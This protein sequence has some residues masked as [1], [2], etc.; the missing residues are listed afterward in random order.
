MSSICVGQ[1]F[2][3][4]VVVK[5]GGRNKDRHRS[6]LCKCKC[7]KKKKVE[8][9][10]LLQDRSTSCGCSKQAD[11][12][13]QRFGSLVARRSYRAKGKIWWECQCDCGKAKL[14]RVDALIAGTTI[15]CGCSRR[16]RVL[17]RFKKL[18]NVW[19]GMLSRCEDPRHVAYKNYG[20]RGILI[21]KS[22]HSF[23]SFKEWAIESE[24][25]PRL[26]IDRID[27]D[28]NYCPGNCQ[29]I[30]KTENGRKGRHVKLDKEK[31]ALIKNMLNTSI[32]QY[33]IAEMF[34]VA[35]S[36][37]SRIKHGTRWDDKPKK[38]LANG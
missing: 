34:N 24:Y 23:E 27:N 29:W 20:G 4:W 19:H 21:C 38:E 1:K 28:S 11:L 22:W 30:T 8:E 16:G 35:G 5:D 14:A 18:R 13:G 10:Y 31:V 25:N 33:E 7:G 36:V 3:Y 17:L 32:K 37:I 15:H 2:N 26:T 12:K 9:R 6:W